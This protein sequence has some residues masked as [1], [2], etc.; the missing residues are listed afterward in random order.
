MPTTRTINKPFGGDPSN[1]SQKTSVNIGAANTG[2]TASEGGDYVNHVTTLTF[3]GLAVG[4]AVGAADLAFGKLLYTLPAGAQLVEAAYTNVAL[5]GTVTIVG[6]TPDVGV[7]SVVAS[8]AVAVLGGTATFEDYITGQTS[9]AIS[10]SNSIEVASAATAGA[11]TGIS[12]NISTSAKTVYLNCADG[13]AGA[14]DVTA[15]GTV[16]LV[17]K[18]IA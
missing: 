7:G 10:G 14:G 8:G 6:D 12:L 17:W 16:V 2:V 13:W 5:T 9:G 11:L 18:T 15:T 3:S 1:V 4:S